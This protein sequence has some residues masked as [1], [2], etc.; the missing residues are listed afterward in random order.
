VAAGPPGELAD[1]VAE[2]V[3]AVPGVHDLHGGVLGEVGTYLPGRRVA[4]V[5]LT[6][7]GCDLHIAATSVA[8]LADTVRAVRAAVRPLVGGRIDVTVEDVVA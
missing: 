5:R 6:D 7:D 3:R 1:V 2:T 4:G 8:P